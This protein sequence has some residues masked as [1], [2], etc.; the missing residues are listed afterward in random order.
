MNT[1]PKKQNKRIYFFAVVLMILSALVIRYFFPLENRLGF[2]K[3]ISID[4]IISKPKNLLINPKAHLFN[5]NADP[6]YKPPRPIYGSQPPYGIV[7]PGEFEEMDGMIIT[8]IDFGQRFMSMWVEMLEVYSK[9]GFTWIIADEDT[10]ES[11]V[12]VLQSTDIP[13]ETYAFLDYPVDSFWIRDYGPEFVV[14]PN[15]ARHIIDSYFL[16]AIAFWPRDDAIPIEIGKD[17]WINA[18][19]SPMEVH[20]HLTPISGGNIMSDGAGTC[21]SSSTIY[22]LEKPKGWSNEDVDELM[23][24][25]FGCEQLII[26][27]PICLESTGHIDM[28]A[29]IVSPNSILLGEFDPDTLFNGEE[30]AEQ[31]GHCGSHYPNDFRDMEINLAILESKTNLDGEPWEVIRMPMLEPFWH[32]DTWI[33]RTYLNAQIFNDQ[34]AMPTYREAKEDET[35]DDLLR[36]ES[37]AIEA[38]EDALPEVVV[39]PIRADHII[40][41]GGAIHCISHE[42]PAEDPEYPSH[43]FFRLEE[44]RDTTEGIETDEE[45]EDFMNDDDDDDNNDDSHVEIDDDDNDNI[46]AKDRIGDPSGEGEVEP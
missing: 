10:R 21:F 7:R 29:K 41:F 24:V 39:T 44:Q 31:T 28:F 45:D 27:K 5:P 26:L 9:A 42:I 35:I 15:G 16:G 17:D 19:G 34:I 13:T 43:C 4:K 37:E 40:K 33:Y 1:H 6:D 46:E 20:S 32:K 25:Y 12:E 30:L 22:T 36:M 14:E 11:L 23:R 8:A 2:A 3:P 38:Y 18:D